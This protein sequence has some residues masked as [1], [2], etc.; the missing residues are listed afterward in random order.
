MSSVLA[1]CGVELRRFLADRSNIF[2]VFIFPLALVFFVGS[3][4]GG[5]GPGGSVVVVGSDSPLRTALVSQLDRLALEVKTA[6]GDE[7]RE[8]VARGGADV[9]VVIPPE[10]V[11]ALDSG[12]EPVLEIIAGSQ[13]N[14]PAIAQVVRN[15]GSAATLRV[16]QERALAQAGASEADIGAALD[17]ADA[18]VDAARVTVEDTSGLA[19]QFRGLGQFD[20]GAAGQLLLFTF[21]TTLAGAVTV[22]QARRQGVV[23][24]IMSA[25]V[26]SGQALVGLALGRLVIALFQGGYIILATWLLFRVNWGD[27]LAVGVLL[28]LFGLVAAG[29]SMILGVL[30]DNEGLATGL[31]VGGGLVLGALGGSMVPLEI[32]PETMRKLAHLT[33]HAWGYD[34]MAEIQR[35]GGGVLDVLPQLGVLAAMA[36]VALALGAWLLRRSLARAM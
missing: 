12:G 8:L 2:F 28:L 6:D 4:F 3:Q 32:F 26:T 21:L 22:I 7:M 30:A 11:T 13:S 36:A 5:G 24:R 14:A 18:Q 1:V 10:A 29:L 16:G 23:K 20:L 25:P 27:P 31:S 9:G 19:Q 34:A 35:H 15:A 17:R 33:P